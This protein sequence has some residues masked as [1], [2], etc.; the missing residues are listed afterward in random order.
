MKKILSYKNFLNLPLIE[1]NNQI[2]WPL[3][4]KELPEW[5]KLQDLGFYDATTPI[6]AKNQTIMLKN[7]DPRVSHVYP[8]GVVLQKIG[9]IRDKGRTS[10]FIKSFKGTDFTTSDLLNWVIE[11]YV[12]ELGRYNNALEK[13]G[14]GLTPDQVNL[15]NKFTK[16]SWSYDEKTREVNVNGDVEINGYTYKDDA[17][18]LNTV[19][20]GRVKGNFYIYGFGSIKIDF[21]PH[22]VDKNFSSTGN[23]INGLEKFPRK[24][25]GILSLRNEVQHGSDDMILS[26][27]GIF[28]IHGIRTLMTP[29]FS[30]ANPNP[31][32]LLD[33][34]VEN[35]FDGESPFDIQKGKNLI[36]TA[37]S[38]Q[39]LAKYYSS[40]PLRIH[41]L[42]KFPDLKKEVLK[43]T[44]MKDLSKISK[45]LDLG[46]I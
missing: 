22:S 16:S 23:V 21:L 6:Q 2:S 15:I 29:Y 32:T 27:K 13:Y 30:V 33:F 31:E 46:M 1:S 41:T 4:W 20:F 34:L 45:A 36:L 17:E 10:G 26:I 9:Y 18:L 35:K 44:G 7:K 5:K 25:G 42:D 28:S 37:I 14:K 39:E 38:S 12:K 19:K 3:N 8:E 40:N 11:R 24:I 43:M